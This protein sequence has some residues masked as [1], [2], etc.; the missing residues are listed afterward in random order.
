MRADA[1]GGRA[2]PAVTDGIPLAGAPPLLAYRRL[3]AARQRILSGAANRIP[4]AS[5]ASQARALG[6]W[7]GRQAKP[8]DEAQFALLMDLGVFDPV[9][10]HGPALERQARAAPPAP[11]SDDAVMLAALA[12]AR[13]GLWRVLG[14]HPD[15][16][17]RL[18]P[19]AGVGTEAWVMDTGLAQ[20]APGAGVAARLAFPE[21]TGFGL[22]C[23]A[24]APCDTRVLQR[25]L[26][27]LAPPRDAPVIPAPPAPG[28]AAV[29]ER[30]LAQP[31][32][33]ARIAT[34]LEGGGLAVRAWRAALDLGLM[35]PVPDRTPAPRE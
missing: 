28:D 21:G 32:T 8:G 13:F 33:R 27:D 11:G 26:L 35:G 22:T 10:G 7:D 31:A 5:V 14:P 30:L 1:R 2:E 17:V 4:L 19:M 34:L 25:L 15:G 20:A 6:L 16:G 3:A 24:L 9:G 29:L 12:A 18:L 23:G